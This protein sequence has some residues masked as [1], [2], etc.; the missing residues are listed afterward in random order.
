[1]INL[2][3]SSFF[4]HPKDEQKENQDSIL[5][6][7]KVGDNYIFA[8]ADGVGSYLGAKEA[9][10]IAVNHLNQLQENELNDMDDIFICIRNKII[11]LSDDIADFENAAT[12]LT[13][14]IF[15]YKG[16][17]IGHIGDCRLYI[18]ENGKLRQK[19]KDHT[20]HQRLLDE[21]IYTKKELK[22][23]PGKN[24][25]NEAIT[26]KI[27]MN[28]NSIFIPMSDITRNNDNIVSFFLMSDG[29]HQHW[30]HRPR[31]SLNTISHT[32]SFSASL[33]KR[34]EKNPTDDY[35]LV[36]VQFKVD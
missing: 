16:L 12:T 4:S 1:M 26:K 27:K 34:I 8:V 33:R 20:N 5:P 25:I 30:E 10:T 7:K 22:E 32:D 14:G 29:A 3:T 35:S 18:E 11:K 21:K 17:T 13:F 2:I 36:A 24:I 9:S 23:L 6:V 28:Y 15:N 19:T 31:F